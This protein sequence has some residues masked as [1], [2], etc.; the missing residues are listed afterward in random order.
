MHTYTHTNTHMQ[1]L[2]KRKSVLLQ[3]GRRSSCCRCVV[4][5]VLLFACVCLEV[6][7]LALYLRGRCVVSS[8]FACVC[9]LCVWNVV[10]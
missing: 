2:Q 6:F 7:V 8:V 3:W 1:V 5:V 9:L 4:F 10:E